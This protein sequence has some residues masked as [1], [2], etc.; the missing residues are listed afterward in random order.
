MTPPKIQ[1]SESPIVNGN[2]IPNG[3]K[4]A[5]VKKAP[6]ITLGSYK[7]DN[8]IEIK[9]SKTVG[10]VKKRISEILNIPENEFIMKKGSHNGAEFKALNDL[11]DKYTSN[12]LNIYIEYGHPQK[13]SEIKINLFTCEYDY[14]FFLV[15]PYK[16]TDVGIFMVDL[17]W[18][19]VE[20]KK[21]LI[22]EIK[23]RRD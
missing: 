17:N 23:K 5:V 16:V 19:V 15:F 22:E 1:S 4:K 10:D 14:S 9:K 3:V 7:F 18:T 2:G 11:I 8:E 12:A 20:L 6:R 21:S 13:D